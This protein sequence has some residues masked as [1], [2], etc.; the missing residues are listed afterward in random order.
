MKTRLVIPG[1]AVPK[2]RPRLNRKTMTLYTPRE[3]KQYE[4]MVALVAQSTHAR[5]DVNTPVSVTITIYTSKKKPADVD[6]AS[7]SILD[8]LQK[9]GLLENDSQVCEL[10]I[11]RVHSEN[12][13]VDITVNPV[14]AESEGSIE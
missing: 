3:T 7:K 12:P 9:G 6:N 5:S 1:E 2:G 10:H 8:G 14:E 11:R 4:E 13:K